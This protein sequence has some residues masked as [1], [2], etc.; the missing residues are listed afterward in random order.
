MQVASLVSA[1]VL[2]ILVRVL[3]DYRGAR[4]LERSALVLAGLLVVQVFLGIA[5]YMILV[6]HPAMRDQ[7]PLPSFVGI[8]TTHVVVGA[9]LLADIEDELLVAPHADHR[10][11][12]VGGVELEIPL[13]V[14]A[15]V[16]LGI[17]DQGFHMDV[18]AVR[19]CPSLHDV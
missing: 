10:G 17:L 8:A 4:A 6:G 13:Y 1:G 2:W 18:I 5:S 3:R 7:Q 11:D 12:A 14:F 15:R 19:S 16:E 9:L